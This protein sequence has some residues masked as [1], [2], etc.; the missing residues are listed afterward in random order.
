MTLLSFLREKCPDAPSVKA[1]KR[2]IEGKQCT[3]NGRVETFSTHRLMTHDQ[4]V[5]TLPQDEQK[6][7]L[8]PLLLWEDETLAA[9]DKPAGLVC[10][11]SHFGDR[12]VHRLDK[13]TSGVILTAKSNPILEKMIHL[14]QQKKVKK[15][16]LA[17]VSGII[18]KGDG[19]SFPIL[20]H[21]TASKGKPFMDPA[22]KDKLRKH[23]GKK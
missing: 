15:T 4:I 21:C 1:L 5:L 7:V 19:L 3:I 11:P 6:V 16:Y 20:L 12:L 23:S 9:Y 18:K 22:P 8:K 13:E 17:I 2:W 10:H 14:F